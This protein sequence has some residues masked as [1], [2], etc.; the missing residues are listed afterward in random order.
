MLKK[1]KSMLIFISKEKATIGIK[2]SKLFFKA[3]VRQCAEWLMSSCRLHGSCSTWPH[4]PEMLLHP[5]RLEGTPVLQEL[6]NK[7]PR[8]SWA[9]LMS[10]AVP[11][12]S[13]GCSLLD[14]ANVLPS[15][16]ALVLRAGSKTAFQSAMSWQARRQWDQLSADG[17]ISHVSSVLSPAFSEICWNCWIL[18]VDILTAK[19]VYIKNNDSAMFHQEK[20]KKK[21][22]N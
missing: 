11:G 2:I 5:T 6:F 18:N 20:K 4:L 13:S 14:P 16:W 22:Y 17:D 10:M 21:E 15:C 9:C 3:K 19:I 1:L 8:G 7:T 12:A